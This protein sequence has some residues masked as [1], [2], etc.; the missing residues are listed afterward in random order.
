MAMSV[1]M[2]LG[3]GSVGRTAGWLLGQ[4]HMGLFR[5][6]L[7][8]RPAD[9]PKQLMVAAP[10][11][12]GWDLPVM[13]ACALC[14]GV[15]IRWIGKKELFDRPVLGWF[16]RA[17]G[18]IPIDRSGGRDTVSQIIKVIRDSEKI[19][20]CIAP[21][22]SRSQRSAWKSGFYHIAVG[23]DVPITLGFIDWKTRTAGCGPTLMPT[24]NVGEDMDRVRAFYSD[25]KGRAPER[26]GPVRLSEEDA[27]AARGVA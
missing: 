4:G 19:I 16:L 10:H 1:T 17:T 22:G 25:V 12:S 8:G 11:T 13:L 2:S 21:E 14:F 5:W 7:V 9:V 18:G 20:L 26:Q 3:L 6:R 27:E 23:A 15:R 24:G